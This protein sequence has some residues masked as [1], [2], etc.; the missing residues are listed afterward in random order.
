MPRPSVVQL[1]AF[2]MTKA[3]VNAVSRKRWL[4]FALVTAFLAAG[5]STGSVEKQTFN[6]LAALRATYIVAAPARGEVCNGTVPPPDSLKPVC[7]S[8]LKVLNAAYVTLKDGSELLAT[9]LEQAEKPEGPSLDGL[10]IAFLPKIQQAIVDVQAVI[11]D[12]QR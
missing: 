5:C 9:Y 4:L 10:L 6:S 8:S 11:K 7:A 12:F 3:C 1:P 2:S